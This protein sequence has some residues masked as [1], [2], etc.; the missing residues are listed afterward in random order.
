MERP[1]DKHSTLAQPVHQYCV[2]SG[3]DFGAVIG[4]LHQF[5]QL[6]PGSDDLT[7]I[8]HFVSESMVVSGSTAYAYCNSLGPAHFNLAQATDELVH[9][10][11]IAPLSENAF[12]WLRQLW[13]GYPIQ[14]IM[15]CTWAVGFL[16]DQGII[17]RGEQAIALVDRGLAGRVGSAN[18]MV[19]V[20]WSFGTYFGLLEAVNGPTA[21][22]YELFA[23]N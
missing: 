11:A 14:K 1:A 18:V 16:F 13:Q 19:Q 2:P 8:R 23:D 10:L 22:F 6:N 21:R 15:I 9:S 17:H 5:R 4:V 3:H 12:N 20:G 7:A